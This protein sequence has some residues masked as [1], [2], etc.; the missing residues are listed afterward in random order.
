MD[1]KKIAQQALLFIKKITL[2]QRIIFLSLIVASILLFFLIGH[3][4]SIPGSFPLYGLKYHIPSKDMQKIRTSLTQ[5]SIPFTVS[6]DQIFVKD[7]TVAMKVKTELGM[8]GYIP[9]GIKGWELFDNQPF[10]TTDFERKINVRR[11][12]TDNIKK[13][14][15]V[16]DEIQSADVVISFGENK[17]F[18]DDRANNPLTASIVLSVNGNSDLLSNKSKIRG[19][20]DLIAQGVSDLNPRN[21][22]IMTDTG[23]VL[24]RDLEVTA[25]DK[26][27]LLAKEHL[28]IKE[29]E[30][31]KIYQEL[32][33][34]L[35]TVF[36]DGRF[37]VKVNLV[38]N[39]DV[40]KTKEHLIL[41]TIIKKDNP[42]TPYDDSLVKESITVSKKS[43]QE[44][45]KGQGYIPE[46]PAGIEDQVPPGLKEKM[47]RYNSYQKNEVID[48]EE[49]SKS[50]REIIRQP[51]IIKKIS[52]SVFLDGSWK[53]VRKSNGEVATKNSS[54]QRKFT[55]VSQQEI[56]SV[57][58]SIKSL[59]GFDSNRGDAVSVSAI[60]FDRTKEFEKYDQKIIDTLSRKRFFTTTALVIVGIFI[61]FI[62]YQ[63]IKK[64]F[65]RRRRLREEEL[66]REQ[67]ALRLANL[68]KT[69]TSL[70][71]EENALLTST[72]EFVKEK[73]EDSAK[74]VRTWLN[75]ED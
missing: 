13:H 21:V 22:V 43:T 35:Q 73:P 63:S 50:D 14:L 68:A 37:D 41:P 67:E 51:Y 27:V 17:Y 74:L 6:G 20:R 28:Q 64:E 61:F 60:K 34:H 10:T 32:K 36:T 58:E 47:D 49:F 69:E 44:Q 2:V 54:I 59:I 39:W 5:M 7:S 26:N 52:V 53:V 18:Q 16:I 71:R 30:R 24:T 3:K 12:I 48:N 31:M 45:F 1:W 38:L 29:Q 56:D 9:Q 75:S 19:L 65:L 42:A 66:L 55:P 23:T 8:E 33:K 46:G 11:A 15:E 57:K 62:I 25:E 40:E 72:I 70:E 4:S